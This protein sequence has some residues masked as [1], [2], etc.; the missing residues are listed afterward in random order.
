MGRYPKV[1]KITVTCTH[2]GK[3]KEIYPSQKIYNEYFCDNKCRAAH[4]HAE[5]KCKCGT[6]RNPKTTYVRGN[7]TL[8]NLCKKCRIKKNKAYNYRL[9]GKK[10][11]EADGLPPQREVICGNDAPKG[12]NHKD[13]WIMKMQKFPVIFADV[14]HCAATLDNI[15]AY[16]NQLF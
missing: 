12:R 7:G 2:C 14:F 8:D 3:E 1:K 11:P 4:K 5:R 13:M 16:A 6:E 9:V 15:K 10:A